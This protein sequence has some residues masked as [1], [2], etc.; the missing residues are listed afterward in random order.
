MTRETGHRLAKLAP[1]P[2]RDGPQPI[3]D[4]TIQTRIGDHLR[5]MYGE[6]LDQ[7]VPDRFKELLAKLD[8]GGG[9][10]GSGET[11]R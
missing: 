8:G 3:L 6:L 1:E 7:P 4:R 10:P 9:G 2:E 11:G 5:G